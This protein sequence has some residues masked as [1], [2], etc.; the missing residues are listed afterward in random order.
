M[1]S[2]GGNLDFNFNCHLF[3][4]S[5][6]WFASR[7]ALSRRHLAPPPPMIVLLAILANIILV[8]SALGFGSLFLRLFPKTFSE[9]DRLTM[10]LLG[11][12]G[13]LGT[14]LFCVGLA[15]YS[16]AAI[17]VVLII[18]ILLSW[19]SLALASRVFRS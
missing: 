14:A 5:R 8:G 18:G 19:K 12:L 6:A 16:R 4:H 15:W 3:L 1:A 9:L 2:P 7:T 10:T 13:L 17:L 11:G